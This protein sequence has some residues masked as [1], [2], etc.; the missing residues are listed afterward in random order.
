[1][2]DISFA[3]FSFLGLVSFLNCQRTVVRTRWPKNV[4]ASAATVAY[5]RLLAILPLKKSN[6]QIHTSCD[7]SFRLGVV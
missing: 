6:R 2:K 1:M 7:L 4:S 5:V 3:P